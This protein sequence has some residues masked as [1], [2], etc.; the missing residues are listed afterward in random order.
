MLPDGV[1]AISVGPFGDEIQTIYSPGLQAMIG[2]GAYTTN[3]GIC[4]FVAYI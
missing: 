3:I 2:Y 4:C 1:W